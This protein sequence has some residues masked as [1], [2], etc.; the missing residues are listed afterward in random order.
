MCFD[1]FGKMVASHELLVTRRAGK[2]LLSGVCSQVSLQLVTSG[3][4]LTTEEPVT[5]KRSLSGVPS[6][7]RLQM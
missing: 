6:Q 1:V 2:S 4:S 7:M 3:E 5:D